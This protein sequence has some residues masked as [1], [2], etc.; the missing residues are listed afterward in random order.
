[1]GCCTWPKNAISSPVFDEMADNGPG[2]GIKCKCPPI[3]CNLNKPPGTARVPT[4]MLDGTS[5]ADLTE[6]WASVSECGASWLDGSPTLESPRGKQMHGEMHFLATKHS[7]ERAQ[8][9]AD[10]PAYNDFLRSTQLDTISP[11]HRR[12]VFDWNIKMADILK[13]S[14]QALLLSFTYFDHYLSVVPSRLKDLQLLSTAC[15]WVASKVCCT[16]CPVAAS[17]QLAS[18]YSDVDAEDI[19]RME[20]KVLRVLKWRVHPTMPYDIVQLIVPCISCD[21]PGLQ[22]KLNHLTEGILFSMALVY[23]LLRFDALVQAATSVACACELVAGVPLAAL[24]ILDRLVDL[25]GA[26]KHATLECISVLRNHVC[27]D[28][29]FPDYRT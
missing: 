23:P 9:Y 6:L 17:T 25:V 26:E 21:H 22:L 28:R 3:I 13:L 8:T 5:L 10:C 12:K 29:L 14:N 4:G 18:L 19:T 15:M 20:I 16:E 1:M 11:A 2:V 24:G 27:L 7:T